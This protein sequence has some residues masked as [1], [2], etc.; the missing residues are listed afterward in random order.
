MN[1]L[2]GGLM[3]T[4]LGW[5][6]LAGALVLIALV[7][8]ALFKPWQTLRHPPLQSP[9]LA[10]LVIL[11]WLWWSPQLLPVGINIHLAGSCLLVLMFGWPLAIYTVL[12]VAV[13]AAIIT[14]I[15]PLGES[16][17]AWAELGSHLLNARHAIIEQALWDGMVPATFALLIGLA[18]RRFLPQHVFVYILGRG[19]ICTAAAV[20]L[21]ASLALWQGA[22]TGEVSAADWLLAHWLL[23]WG[24]A[25]ATGMLT[26][27][28]VAVSPQWLLTYTDL[29]YLPPPDEPPTR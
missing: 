5:P 3:N 28:F 15:N 11:P 2:S 23:A 4:A 18:I 14:A 24:E 10:M 20:M 13:G 22:A 6:G 27:I 12:G 21:S 9:W 7:V 8:S 19:F 17:V 29:R 26:A 25:F 1:E 16:S